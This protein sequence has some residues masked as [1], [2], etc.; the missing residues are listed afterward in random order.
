[1]EEVNA[2]A[3]QP[4]APMHAAAEGLSCADAGNPWN[5]RFRSAI[6]RKWMAERERP[7]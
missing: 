1:M 6:W 2:G 4:L 3:H 5:R 7:P